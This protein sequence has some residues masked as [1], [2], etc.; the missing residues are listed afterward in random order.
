MKKEKGKKENRRRKEIPSESEQ[1]RLNREIEETI[2]ELESG[3]TRLRSRLKRIQ[4]KLGRLQQQLEQQPQGDNPADQQ[5]DA[6]IW[7]PDGTR[8]AWTA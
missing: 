3:M 7:S 5:G 2:E 8:G 1:E 4:D 6:Y